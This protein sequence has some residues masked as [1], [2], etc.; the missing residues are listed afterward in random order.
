MLVNKEC[1]LPLTII[2]KGKKHWGISQNIFNVPKKKES[3]KGL[4]Q[5]EGEL[6][7][8]KFFRVDRHVFFR[9]EADTD[10]Y[11]SSRS[12]TDILNRYMSGVKMYVKIKNKGYD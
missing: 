9:A 12:I 8:K 6:K 1:W 5:H 11:R 3:H 10:Y 2:C 7:K 4:K